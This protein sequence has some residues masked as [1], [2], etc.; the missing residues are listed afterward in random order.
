MPVSSIVR[1][2]GKTC[3]AALAL[4]CLAAPAARSQATDTAATLVKMEKSEVGVSLSG[5][6]RSEFTQAALSGTSANPA[7]PTHENIAFT[8]AD[9]D[10]DARPSA[11][12]R[13]KLIFRLHQ[14]WENYYDEGPNPLLARWF[15]FDGNLADGKVEFAV[16]DFREK[17]SPL[18]L[19]A[20]EPEFLY[21]PEIFKDKRQLAMDEWFL[22]DNRLPL[23]GVHAT[24]K[25]DWP[26]TVGVNAGV[27]AARLRSGASGT[28]SWPFWTDDA[29][30]LMGAGFLKVKALDAVELGGTLVRITDNI[31]AARAGSNL[32]VKL[33]PFNVYEDVNVVAGNLGL[34]AARF[35]KHGGFFARLDAELALSDYQRTHDDTANGAPL[36]KDDEKLDGKAMDV[37]LHAG[38]SRPD[39]IFSGFTLDAAFLNNDADYV[40]DVAQ[41]PVFWGRRILNSQNGVAGY[42]QGYGTFDALYNHVYTVDPVTNLNTSEFWFQDTKAYNG[43]NNWYRAASFKNSYTNEAIT[44]LERDGF[45]S[46]PH[47]ALL[48][49]FGPATPDRQGVNLSATAAFLKKRVDA[50]VLFAALTEPEGVKIDSVHKAAAATYGRMGAGVQVQAGSLLGLANRITVSGSYVADTWKRGSYVQD[51]LTFA[52]GSFKSEMI[53]AGLYAGIFKHLALLAGYQ[54]IVSNPAV[55]STRTGNTVAPDLGEYTQTNW[56]AGLEIKLTHGAYVTG[57]YGMMEMKDPKTNTDFSQKIMDLS[58]LVAF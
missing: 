42:T 35:L 40:N 54:Q 38:Y 12:T 43:T 45:H 50:T 28:S 58:L 18:T 1:R 16:G 13:G 46:D 7:Q 20:P 15:D 55:G 30:K 41:S 51:S 39:G 53:N 32:Y 3:G 31:P 21:E 2:A 8:Q 27:T 19:Y 47:V 11:N 44:K 22:G 48:F 25:Q 14:D 23:Q 56:S 33:N 36:L 26:S 24:Y 37:T 34:D 5:K 4:A 52:A 29:D 10:L 6:S 9:I 49:P 57:D 17:Y